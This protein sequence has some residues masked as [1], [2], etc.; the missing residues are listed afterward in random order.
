M[1]MHIATIEPQ[2]GNTVVSTAVRQQADRATEARSDETSGDGTPES[3]AASKSRTAIPLTKSEVEAV[4]GTIETSLVGKGVALSFKVL[5]D[6]SNGLQV[7][8]RDASSGRLIRK[9]PPDELLALAKD[10]KK[11]TGGLLD[12]PA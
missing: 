10:L 1:D 6:G 2:D 3:S 5:E 4:A 11:T 12:K 7:E 9:T 8:I